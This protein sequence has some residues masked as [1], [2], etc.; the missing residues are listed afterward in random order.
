MP[1]S[2]RKEES[3][4]MDVTRELKQRFIEHET[5]DALLSYFLTRSIPFRQDDVMR[6]IV[7]KFAQR[8]PTREDAAKMVDGYFDEEG[9]QILV[10]FLNQHQS[11]RRAGIAGDVN[12]WVRR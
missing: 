3:I 1:L 5:R 9:T 2:Q 10:T 12:I 8:A 4:G 11:L 7:D 6:Q